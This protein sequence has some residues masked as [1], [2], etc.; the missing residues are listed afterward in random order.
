M[1]AEA[2]HLLVETQGSWNGPN[3]IRFLEDAAVLAESGQPVTVLLLQDGVFTA[4]AGAGRALDRLGALGVP[5]WVDDFSLAQRALPAGRLPGSAT[6]TGMDAVAD[7]LL[8]G[9]CRV[10]WH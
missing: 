2:R 10:V 3:A 7:L 6:V 5:I 1:S 9:S 8:S 4:V